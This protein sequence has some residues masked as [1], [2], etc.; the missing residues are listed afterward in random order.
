MI[1]GYEPQSCSE[2]GVIQG[3]GRRSSRDLVR[4][5]L[6][7]EQRTKKLTMKHQ[8]LNLPLGWFWLLISADT[9]LRLG[10]IVVSHCGI[11]AN[12]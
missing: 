2:T 6:C 11:L 10:C 7:E 1:Y 8:D 12:V 4:Y 3:A 9:G 5:R